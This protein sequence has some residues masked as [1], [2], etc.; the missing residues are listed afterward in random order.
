M[1]FFLWVLV[2]RFLARFC[3]LVMCGLGL[4]ACQT[5][6]GP[7]GLLADPGTRVFNFD[8]R[9]SGDPQVGPMQV[10]DNGARIW[11]HFAPEQILPAVLG[12]RNGQE[13]LLPLKPLGQF[14][15]IEGLWT[16]LIF[17]A[18]RAQAQASLG[19][20]RVHSEGSA[21]LGMEVSDAFSQD[22]S[23]QSNPQQAQASRPPLGGSPPSYFP[24]SGSETRSSEPRS[25]EE[26]HLLPAQRVPGLVSAHLK[27]GEPAPAKPLQTQAFQARSEVLSVSVPVVGTESTEQPVFEL[28]IKDR[29]LRQ[30]LVRWAK[31]AKWVFA[32]EHWTLEVDFPIKAAARFEGSFESAV[33]QL[34]A[35][36]QLN[37]HP[38]QACFYS[39]QVL[40]VL[41]WPQACDPSVPPEGQS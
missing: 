41:A 2:M 38:L 15:V 7:D 21:L 1:G 19:R 17:R 8:W 9:L 40:R 29:T 26:S 28:R 24:L 6:Q 35:A 3:V 36:A 25:P 23:Q 10:F 11:L 18:G 27:E 33:A 5:S 31:Q 22:R 14:Q 32:P 34:F 13:V 30:A 12:H 4:S 20:K 37:A 39:N 16:E